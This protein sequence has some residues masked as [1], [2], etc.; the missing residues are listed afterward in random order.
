MKPNYLVT[1]NEETNH[2]KVTSL[3]GVYA[4]VMWWGAHAKKQRYFLVR[5]DRLIIK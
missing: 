3:H 4:R 2:D 5:Q 1:R